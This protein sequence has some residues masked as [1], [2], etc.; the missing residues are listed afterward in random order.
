MNT[1][2]TQ[3]LA[4]RID[5]WLPQTQCTQCGYPRCRLYADAVAR[6]DADINRCPPGGEK[7]IEQLARLLNVPSKP[8]DPHYGVYQPRL[9]AVIDENTCIGCKLCIQACPVDA[10]L[11]TAKKMHTVIATEC[12]GCELCVPP[13]PVACIDMVPF[14]AQGATGN[15]PWP[16]YAWEHANRARDRAQARLQRLAHQTRQGQG[17]LTRPN[18]AKPTDRKSE[19]NQDI[20]EE[21]KAAVQRVRARKARQNATSKT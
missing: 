11:G 14:R 16:D 9:V 2:R 18:V 20:R 6:G 5:H 17:K 15:W 12:T 3:A 10:I 1:D 4:E 13:C 8:L 21:I 19:K 7:T